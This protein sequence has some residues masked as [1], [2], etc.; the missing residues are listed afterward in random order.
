MPKKNARIR[1]IVA[2]D[3]FCGV[4]GTTHGFVTAGIPV[5]MG[6]DIDPSCRFAYETNNPGATFL[7]KSV[8]DLNGREVGSWFPKGAVRVLIG[9]A[10]CQPFSKYT[11]R[12][13][14]ARSSAG[15][16]DERWGLLSA[17]G[18]VVEAVRPE[19]VTA[20]NVP[21]LA[22]QRHQ[23]YDRFIRRLETLGYF[24]TEKI[25][26]CADYGV[27]QSRE[28]LV[29]LASLI[30]TIEMIHPTHSPSNY[31]TVREQISHLPPITAGG[32]PPATDPLHRSCGL[33]PLNLSRIRATPP[34]GGWQDW[35]ERLRLACHK[36]ESG[37]TYPS[38]YGRIGWDGLAPTITTQCFGLGNGRFGHPDQDRAISLREAALLQT[39]PPNYRFVERG[40]AVRYNRI[41]KH[42]GNAVPVAL[43]AAIA[44]SI[45]RH[46][47]DALSGVGT[48]GER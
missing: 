23:V 8:E 22:L 16:R 40:E 21:Q 10:P 48:R 28:R 9:C 29:V 33:S 32:P 19:I 1:D 39:F 7:C 20:E 42:I 27:P 11:F 46:L 43:G 15:S 26:K 41:G 12:Y 14:G 34:N 37:K 31:V 3:L 30:G 5:K 47:R 6:V 45:T 36:R 44:R 25:V 35:P 24:V 4:G 38:V 13:G 18:D 17:F 2:V